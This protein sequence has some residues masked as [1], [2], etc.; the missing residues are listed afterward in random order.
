ML[1]GDMVINGVKF[2][3]VIREK[4]IS[5]SRPQSQYF[6]RMT[7]DEK[8]MYINE[9]LEG[10]CY[11]DDHKIVVFTNNITKTTKTEITIGIDYV[12]EFKNEDFEIERLII[13]CKELNRIYDVEG[14]ITDSSP[15]GSAMQLTIKPYA[16][17]VTK[18]E[19]FKYAGKDMEVIFIIGFRIYY[20][21]EQ[22]IEFGSQLVITFDKTSDYSFVFG[23]YRMAICFLMYL[24]YRRNIKILKTILK[25]KGLNMGAI[26]EATL[27]DMIADYSEN[28]NQSAYEYRYIGHENIQSHVGNLFQ[29]LSDKRIY[30]EHIPLSSSDRLHISIARF[31]LITAAFE[32]EFSQKYHDTIEASSKEQA[33][34]SRVKQHLLDQAN[35][36][37]SKEKSIYKYLISQVD[38]NPLERKLKVAFKN[39]EYVKDIVRGM[40]QANGIEVDYN[41]ISSRIQMQRNN[42]AHGNI[43]KEMNKLAILD[44]VY[45]QYVVF[46]MQLENIGLSNEKSL[47]CIQQLSGLR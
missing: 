36:T 12:L 5:I 10:N 21:K 16:Q 43:D 39:Y 33:A 44:V 23:L 3:F 47:A 9:Q 4:S 42:Y 8:K 38:H 15:D 25:P 28:E 22:P 41:K 2:K 37:T 14:C 24:C 35:I 34:K 40:Y 29:A 18:P 20:E 26:K 17:L 30:I 1:F 13:E 7:A 6:V 45:L 11:P 32:W 46:A 31:V 27:I 19:K